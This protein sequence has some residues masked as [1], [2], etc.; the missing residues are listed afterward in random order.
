MREYADWYEFALSVYVNSSFTKES[1]FDLQSLGLKYEKDIKINPQ[2][3]NRQC[4]KD[5]IMAH[6]KYTS[7]NPGSHFD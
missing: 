6:K 2:Q 5:K 1:K 7:V 3:T 4:K